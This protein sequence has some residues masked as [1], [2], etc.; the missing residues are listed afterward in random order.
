MLVE[1][2][3]IENDG[4]DT[5]FSICVVSQQDSNDDKKKKK[6]DGDFFHF[7]FRLQLIVDAC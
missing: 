7:S 6:N 4:D 3:T 5:M 2:Y 1:H